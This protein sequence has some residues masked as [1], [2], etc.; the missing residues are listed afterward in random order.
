MRRI[1]LATAIGLILG[2]GAA[3]AADLAE[4]PALDPPLVDPDPFAGFYI[5]ANIG[6]GWG[7]LPNNLPDIAGGLGFAVT[8]GLNDADGLFGGLQAGYNLTVN[9]LLF[10]IEGEIGLSDIGDDLNVG[11]VVPGS[12]D[13]QY[14]GIVAARAGV[15]P[16]ESLLLFVKGGYAFGEAKARV[17]LTALGGG[18]VEDTNFHNGWT[19]GGG[20]EYALTDAISVKLEYNYIDLEQ[21]DFNLGLGTPVS[22]GFDGHM[23]KIGVNALF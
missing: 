12:A 17:D 11:G 19:V 15:L 2:M 13:L 5:G 6:Y 7:E 3:Q 23:V 18:V 9:S 8:D 1:G 21:Q 22:A 20:A 4:I 14:F 10:G 16:T